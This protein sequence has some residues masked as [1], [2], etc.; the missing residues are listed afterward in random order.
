MSEAQNNAQ[1]VFKQQAAA[2]AVATF[3][4]SGMRVGLGSGSTA[5]LFVEELG[6]RASEGKF[7][8]LVAVSTSEKTTALARTYGL[9][10]V[11]L[12]DLADLDV[13]IDGADE[14]DPATFDVVKGRGGALLRE[15]MVAAATHIEVIIA[16]ESK[17]VSQLGEKMPLPVETIPFGWRHTAERLR[18]LGGEPVL[19]LRDEKP[20]LTDSNNYV[21]D[22]RFP[23]IEN[24]SNLSL[25]VKSTVGVVEHGLF[26]GVAK[27][28]VIAGANGVYELPPPVK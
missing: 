21:L 6:L 12:N 7:Q 16:D 3:I 17:L 19:R 15:K 9:K 1:Q 11:E 20:Y 2:Y 14:I 13:T 28:V 10:V 5:E 22:C 26:V 23:P 27:R 18:K 8:N 4:Q 24:P 25:L